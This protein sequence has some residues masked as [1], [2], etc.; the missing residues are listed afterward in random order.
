MLPLTKIALAISIILLLFAAP[1]ARED[2]DWIVRPHRRIVGGCQ[3]P[4][5]ATA[6][7]RAET[8]LSLAPTRAKCIQS[9]DVC[10][11][12]VASNYSAFQYRAASH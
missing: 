6:I 3:R 11:P 8:M 7:D 2:F 9:S 4:V 5:C 10:R 1:G 12:L